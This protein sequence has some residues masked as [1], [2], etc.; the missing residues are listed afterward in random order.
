MSVLFR[1]Y[2][3]L[4]HDGFTLTHT[5]H[6]CLPTPVKVTFSHFIILLV[7]FTSAGRREKFLVLIL[8]LFF[9]IFFIFIS[10]S[11]VFCSDTF[12]K[13]KKIVVILCYSARVENSTATSI[14][15][16]TVRC[17]CKNLKEMFLFV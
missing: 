8:K 16:W 3:S 14:L 7:L 11:P 2:L 4:N 9:F 15:N 13:Q 5:D 10:L 12:N 17:L 6:R 1:R